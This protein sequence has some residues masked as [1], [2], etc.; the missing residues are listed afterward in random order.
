MKPPI[1]ASSAVAATVGI[2]VV[3]FAVNPEN[4]CAFVVSGGCHPICAASSF[5]RGGTLRL[6]ADLT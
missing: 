6:V 3:G 2:A 1:A 4:V 5:V